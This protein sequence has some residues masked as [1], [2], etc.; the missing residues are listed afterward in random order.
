MNLSKTSNTGITLEHEWSRT[1]PYCLNVIVQTSQ[2]TWGICCK[3]AHALHSLIWWLSVHRSEHCFVHTQC[4]QLLQFLLHRCC[5][6]KRSTTLVPR[7]H[8]FVVITSGSC[9]YTIPHYIGAVQYSAASF[10]FM[11]IPGFTG[12][13]IPL[14]YST[15]QLH[16]DARW[17]FWESTNRL[18]LFIIY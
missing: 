5:T 9:N 14:R 17:I 6:D 13:T 7:A 15:V 12:Y 11:F 16:S 4:G 1:A 18:F 2:A 8:T 3:H 10:M